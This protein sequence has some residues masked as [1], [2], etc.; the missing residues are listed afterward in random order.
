MR[1]CQL[2]D[3][4]GLKAG[5]FSVAE[6]AHRLRHARARVLAS[7]P[8]LDRP[9]SIPLNQYATSPAAPQGGWM[10]EGYNA[11]ILR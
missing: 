4:T 3:R 7:S 1:V 9:V 5:N 11:P 6:L 10:M 2:T 8:L